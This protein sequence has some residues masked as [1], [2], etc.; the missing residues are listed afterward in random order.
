MP[1]KK[2]E[3]Q[4]AAKPTKVSAKSAKTADKPETRVASKPPAVSQTTDA[5]ALAAID[6]SGQLKYSTDG[7]DWLNN[8]Q[9]R[10]PAGYYNSLVAFWNTA[11]EPVLVV[12]T[13]GG[14]W[15]IDVWAENFL[16]DLTSVGEE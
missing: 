1:I 15:M 5:A 6:T 12:G 10:L 11:G 3:S 7:I 14:I 4:A 9:L 13:K 8:V 16:G 2:P